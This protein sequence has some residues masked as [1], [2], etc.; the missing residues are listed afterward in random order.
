MQYA[1]YHDKELPIGQISTRVGLRMSEGNTNWRQRH[2]TD[3]G[4]TNKSRFISLKFNRKSD[5]SE[6]RSSDPIIPVSESKNVQI[7]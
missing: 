3:H 6:R 1:D 4:E 2:V 7:F 5:P